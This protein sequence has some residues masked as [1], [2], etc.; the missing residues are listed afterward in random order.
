MT[1]RDSKVMLMQ[2]ITICYEIAI[3]IKLHLQHYFKEDST[4]QGV[5]PNQDALFRNIRDYWHSTEGEMFIWFHESSHAASDVRC[6]VS[7]GCQF[8]LGNRVNNGSAELGEV[9]Q[10]VCISYSMEN[11]SAN[12]GDFSSK[13]WK[14]NYFLMSSC[15]IFLWF[16]CLKLLKLTANSPN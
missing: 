10:W 13:W 3:K 9:R 15:D 8:W 5:N 1:G 14:K 12:C 7:K 2:M 11:T 6:C 4:S 16:H